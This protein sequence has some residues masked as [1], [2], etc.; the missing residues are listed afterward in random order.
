M[1]VYFARTAGGALTE[2]WMSGLSREKHDRVARYKNENDKM[3]ALTA[4]RLL[5]RVL[6]QE[7]GLR[8]SPDDW[9]TGDNGKPYLKGEKDIHFNISHSGHVAMCALYNRPVGV[10]IERVR[11]VNDDLAR[12]IMSEEE[13]RVYFLA[14]D[15]ENLFFKIWTLK[16][17][18][19]KYKGIGIG[20]AL[21]KLSV[22]P[23]GDGIKT[24]VSGCRFSLI[25]SVSGYQAAVCT[26]VI[27]GLTAEWVTDDSP[28]GY[29][30]SYSR[31][32][33]MT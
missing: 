24:N 14:D 13:W 6:Y 33:E 28:D 15:K 23:D 25:G 11:P 26:D 32:T 22:Y 8:P 3:L 2:A 30:T 19:L 20:Y 10:D 9:A 21:Q 17:A 7:Y 27:T 4:H 29:G 1:K 18:Y 16:E 5:C 12:R 31:C